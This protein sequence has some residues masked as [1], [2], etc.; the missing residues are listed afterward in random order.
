MTIL[1]DSN[2]S[3]FISS[4]KLPVIVDFW[5]TWCNPCKQMFP[6]LQSFATKYKDK[7]I[8][9]KVNIDENPGIASHLNITSIPTLLFFKNNKIVGTTVGVIPESKILQNCESFL[10]PR[11]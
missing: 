9:A 3:E 1:Q 6:T 10:E 11:N 8:V 7:Y 2:F 5:A 4:A